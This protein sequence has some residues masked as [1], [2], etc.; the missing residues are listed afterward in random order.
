MQEKDRRV[1]ARAFTL[2]ELLVVVAIISILAAI[3]FPVFARAR[4]SAR[5]TACLSNLK[6][7]NMA[8]RMYADDYDGMHVRYSYPLPGAVPFPSAKWWMVIDPY[9]MKIGN[10]VTGRTPDTPVLLTCPSAGEL[11][12]STNGYRGHYAPNI[13]RYPSG[14]NAG[15]VMCGSADVP[16]SAVE[17]PARTIWFFDAE[18]VNA[19]GQKVSVDHGGFVDEWRGRFFQP[20][21]RIA[22]RHAGGSWGGG[23]RFN[24]LYF[25]GHVKSTRQTAAQNWYITPDP[26]TGQY[27]AD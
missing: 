22:A 16:D 15:C 2:I 11:L 4:E 1:Q 19:Q 5:S 12:A 21:P 7:L 9:L 27:P 8:M 25:D 3:L 10:L 23:G 17:E 6:Q 20:A 26:E 24:A 14:P 18:F 13:S